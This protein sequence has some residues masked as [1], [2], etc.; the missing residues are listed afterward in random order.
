MPVR[1]DPSRNITVTPWPDSPPLR[2]DIAAGRPP[3]AGRA[4]EAMWREMCAANPRLHDGEI[5]AV[6]SV[7]TRNARIE[8]RRESY[9]RFVTSRAT[10]EAIE[11]LG[12]TGVILH[13]GAVLMGRRAR[14]VRIYAGLWE[15]APRGAID[16]PKGRAARLTERQIRQA[17]RREGRE[18][19]GAMGAPRPSRLLCIVRDP[20]ASSLD[21][22]YLCA[23][24]PSKQAREAGSWEY[25]AM[26]WMSRR[27]LL[28]RR[29]LS[30]PTRALWLAAADHLV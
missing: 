7:E 30:P 12:V 27:A 25:Q 19:L 8:C 9:K 24:A 5:L 1:R 6:N 15:T 28:R 17:L 26:R 22:C 23:W 4:R 20:V 14:G 10:G 13:D 21:L 11:A 16:V 3:A 2:I 18:E 29:D